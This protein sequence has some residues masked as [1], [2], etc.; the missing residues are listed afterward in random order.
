MS[1]GVL[2]D[3]PADIPFR[4][5]LGLTTTYCLT[6]NQVFNYFGKF[7]LD[8]LFIIVK[9]KTPVIYAGDI[10]PILKSSKR[11]STLFLNNKKF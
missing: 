1:E 4:D 9:R 2:K 8:K 11:D 7:L 6:Y 3:T 5:P 10:I